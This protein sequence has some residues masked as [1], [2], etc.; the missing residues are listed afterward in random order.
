[1]SVHLKINSQ[2]ETAA[3]EGGREGE[4]VE[5]AKQNSYNCQGK[6]PS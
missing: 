1:M 3:R 2:S 5:K 4:R 6:E